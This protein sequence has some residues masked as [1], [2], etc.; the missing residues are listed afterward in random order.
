M[1][2]QAVDRCF[3]RNLRVDN[4]QCYGAKI[5]DAVEC[6]FDGLKSSS[7]RGDA[8]ALGL[9]QEGS[10]PLELLRCTVGNGVVEGAEE[11]YSF[12]DSARSNIQGNPLITCCVNTTFGD[13]TATDCGGGYKVENRS[14]D[15]GF[16]VMIF[17]GGPNGTANSGFKI[18]GFAG[19][20]PD[21]I[22]V[23]A[24]ISKSCFAE[25]LRFTACD[26]CKVLSYVGED[27]AASA[28][29]N[30]EVFIEDAFGCSV[31]D[32]KSK[33]CNADTTLIQ[34]QGGSQRLQ[35]GQ[36]HAEGHTVDL[37]AMNT[38]CTTTFGSIMSI[39]GNNRIINHNS[40]GA[41]QITTAEVVMTSQG[42]FSPDAAGGT[43]SVRQSFTGIT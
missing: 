11:G 24:V 17:V 35:F 18:Q 20:R 6:Q 41:A 42:S 30:Q 22:T 12:P 33:N 37:I 36:A 27:N 28:G 1:A 8:Y 16:G 13:W 26:N 7:I 15:S 4:S 39:G 31:A 21:G 38:A 25:G 40:S 10:V 5:V 14:L 34:V 43:I 2:W 19:G 32:F 23:A 3:I 9:Q 29:F